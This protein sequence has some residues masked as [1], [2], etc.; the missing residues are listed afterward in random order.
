M[1]KL[2]FTSSL[3][4]L[5]AA[6][7]FL[8]VGCASSMED[9][10][11]S[12]SS[13]LAS[14]G[15]SAGSLVISQ[16]FGGSGAFVEIFN[17]TKSSITMDGLSIQVAAGSGDFGVDTGSVVALSGTIKAGG[18]YLVG[19]TGGGVA[20]T[21]ATAAFSL[22]SSDGKVLIATGTAAVAC[23]GSLNCG[24]A[25]YLDLL[26]YGGAT[27]FEGA[28]LTGMDGGKSAQRKGGGCTDTNN[29][30]N[31][32]TTA[33]PAPRNA[34]TAV[35]LCSTGSK[36]AGGDSAS[37][38][39]VT[40][41]NLPDDPNAATDAGTDAGKSNVSGNT[42]SSGCAIG[43]VGLGNASALGLLFAAGVA[44]AGRRRRRSHK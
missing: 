6:A 13:A 25:A 19:R 21:D 41:P 7:A 4:C 3:L 32:F 27:Q 38:I 23:G 2:Y 18:H 10:V 14:D 5:T 36:D 8:P 34:T 22:D 29:N 24:P 15:G 40:D 31:D 11:N 17:P 9:S 30:S 39:G 44:V 28:K 26:G 16:V 43:T 42:D 20:N 37:P 1:S 35:N 33:A 12:T